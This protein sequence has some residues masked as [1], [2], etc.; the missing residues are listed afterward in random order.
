MLPLM[1]VAVLYFGTAVRSCHSLQFIEVTVLPLAGVG[2]SALLACPSWQAIDLPSLEGP[3]T[4]YA[5]RSHVRVSVTSVLMLTLLS[6][7][8]DRLM[9]VIEFA[10]RSSPHLELTCILSR[11]CLCSS[12]AGRQC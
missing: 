11:F 1:G 5:L 2:G 12:I 6:S 9:P 3:V 8:S 10:H 4:G 7:I